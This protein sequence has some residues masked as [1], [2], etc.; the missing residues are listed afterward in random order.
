MPWCGWLMARFGQRAVLRLIAPAQGIGLLLVVLSPDVTITGIAML[1]FGA[2]CGSTDVA[3][4]AATVTVERRLSSAVMS[5]MHGFWSLGGFAGGAIGG[6]FIERIGAV[7]HAAAV[8]VIAVGAGL[9]AVRYLLRRSESEVAEAKVASSTTRPRGLPTTPVIYLLGLM[10]L[11]VFVTEGAVLDWGALYMNQERGADLGFAG[12]AYALFAGA[13]AIMRFAGDTVRN[14]FG[15]V[16]TLRWS[17]FVGGGAML[18]AALF[19]SPVLVVAA[20]AVCGL[21]VANTVPVVFSAAGNMPGMASGTG[22]SIVTTMGYSGILLA[23]A[24]I[25]FIAGRTGFVPIFIVLAGLI[26]LVGLGAGLAKPADVAHPP[27]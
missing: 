20:F 22:M 2:L 16:A 15:A 19:P 6:L 11:S 13:M 10:A 12:F 27:A 25:G 7:S 26:V 5:S 18:A 21:G 4:N 9:V 24:A 1:L 14:R 23:P 17:A 8:A 3:M